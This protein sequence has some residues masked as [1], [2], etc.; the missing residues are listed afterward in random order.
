MQSVIWDPIPVNSSEGVGTEVSKEERPTHR[1][2]IETFAV[3]IQKGMGHWAT[4]SCLLLLLEVGG[5][6]RPQS[7]CS[8]CEAPTASDKASR[9]KGRE[10]EL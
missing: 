8:S 2:I 4:G 10:P 7:E 9:K 1:C 5:R 6:T 3:G